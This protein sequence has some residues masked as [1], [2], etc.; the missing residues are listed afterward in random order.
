MKRSGFAVVVSS[1]SGGGKTTLV[2]ALLAE[3]P[4]V[5]RVVTATTRAP[6]LGEKDGVDYHFWTKARF[7]RE[8]RT[9]GLIEHARVFDKCYGVPRKAVADALRRGKIP[10]LVI[11]VQGARTVARKFKDAVLIF[12]LPPSW[13]TLEKRLR[14]RRDGTNNIALRLETA[15]A[16]ITQ[17]EHYGY[18]VVNNDIDKAV[19]EIS[20]IITAEKM[21][22]SRRLAGMRG[23]I[24]NYRFM[25]D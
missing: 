11:D 22:T 16:E 23:G 12:V 20:A 15:R 17:A 9:G 21:K 25:E 8:I 6:R 1:P 7:E 24:R 3:E 2:N 5:T 18:I 4:L 13:K 10:V 19:G 14:G